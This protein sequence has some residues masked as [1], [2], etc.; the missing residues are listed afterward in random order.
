MSRNAMPYFIPNVTYKLEQKPINKDDGTHYPAGFNTFLVNFVSSDNS[1][2]T[3]KFL[4]SIINNN[5]R[6][7]YPDNTIIHLPKEI[8]SKNFYVSE[9]KRVG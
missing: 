6:I 7:P 2:Y 9:N 5:I 4:E 1:E 8:V 3:F